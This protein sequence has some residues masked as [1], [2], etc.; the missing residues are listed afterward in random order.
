MKIECKILS[1]ASRQ[2]PAYLRW[3][4]ESVLGPRVPLPLTILRVGYHHFQSA[5][6]AADEALPPG[7]FD[8]GDVCACRVGRQAVPDG[9]ARGQVSF[10]GG[11]GVTENGYGCLRLFLGGTADEKEETQNQ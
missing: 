4:D 3:L 11:I 7:L 8:G 2:K 6:V 5:T 9:M 1:T 10:E